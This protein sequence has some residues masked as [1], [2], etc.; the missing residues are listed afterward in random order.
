MSDPKLST[1]P[2]AGFWSTMLEYFFLDLFLKGTT[3][4][5]K[6]ILFSPWLLQSPECY[7]ILALS[8]K[9][10]TSKPEGPQA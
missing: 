5:Y 2:N 9:P 1:R 3:I 4:K 7:L 10:Q 6:S 8:P